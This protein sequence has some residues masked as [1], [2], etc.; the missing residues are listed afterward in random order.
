MMDIVI[1]I[2][3]MGIGIFLA[4]KNLIPKR[5]KKDIGYCQTFALVF[6]LGVLG[7][8]LGSNDDIVKKIGTMG[9][10]AILITLFTIVF[11]ILV[12]FLVYRKGER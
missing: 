11:T 9:V 4:K 1:Y 12:I 2:V 5:M 10:E 7:Y 3:V 8:K 6:L